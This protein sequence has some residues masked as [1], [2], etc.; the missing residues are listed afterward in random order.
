MR[1]L[2]LHS[3]RSIREAVD[4]VCAVS[5]TAPPFLQPGRVACQDH[6]HL[7]SPD[8]PRGRTALRGFPGSEKVV[9]KPARSRG[10]IRSRPWSRCLL[11]QFVDRILDRVVYQLPVGNRIPHAP[12]SPARRP[13]AACAAEQTV[14]VKSSNLLSAGGGQTRIKVNAYDNE[15]SSRGCRRRQGHH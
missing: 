11:G 5:N 10:T 14:Y 15:T 4:A 3:L 9:E 1:S 7:A 2:H 8:R 13:D 6:R 12:G